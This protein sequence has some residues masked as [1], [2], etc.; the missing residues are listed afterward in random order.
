MGHT[1][2]AELHRRTGQALALLL[3]IVAYKPQGI[4]KDSITALGG[5]QLLSCGNENAAA[6][7]LLH[8]CPSQQ[9]KRAAREQDRKEKSRGL[10]R[11]AVAVMR[12]D[13]SHNPATIAR[14]GHLAYPKNLLPGVW[15]AAAVTWRRAMDRR[16]LYLLGYGPQQFR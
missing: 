12:A 15:R 1:K 6:G 5:R 10:N 7:Q 8:D 13:G 16:S 11:I 14:L 3:Y 2:E 9:R 4:G